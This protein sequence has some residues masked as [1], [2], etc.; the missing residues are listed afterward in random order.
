MGIPYKRRT[1]ALANKSDEIEGFHI[2]E[3]ILLRPRS[4]KNSEQNTNFLSFGHPISEFQLSGNSNKIV[5]CV[6]QQHEL[7]EKNKYKYLTQIITMER[8]LLT[9]LNKI[10]SM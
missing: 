8:I 2:V 4:S 7:S 6:S 5:T 3:H 1:L 9:M 10:H